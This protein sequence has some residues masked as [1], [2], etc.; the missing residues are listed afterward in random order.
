MGVIIG[1]VAGGV[2]V[3]IVGIIIGVKYS[4]KIM[5]RKAQEEKIAKYEYVIDS[6]GETPI[7]SVPTKVE[8]FDQKN[9]DSSHSNKV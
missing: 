5:G 2:I 6:P 9:D 1:V 7:S 4:K 8:S 3:A